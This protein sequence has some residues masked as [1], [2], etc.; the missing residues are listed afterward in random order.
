MDAV[1]DLPAQTMADEPKSL[2]PLG[3]AF[4]LALSLLCDLAVVELM[5]RL[6]RNEL[7]PF[8]T[9]RQFAL[10]KTKNMSPAGLTRGPITVSASELRID[11]RV[12]PA[13]DK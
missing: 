10:T 12:K 6:G 7:G 1:I 5:Q 3:S 13:Y 11:T 2:L 4:E 9:P 8:G